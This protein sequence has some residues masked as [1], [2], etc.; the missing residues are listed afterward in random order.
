ETRELLIVEGDHRDV[1]SDLQPTFGH[2]LVHAERDV[3]VAGDDGGAVGMSVEH[4]VQLLV[5]D[6]GAPAIDVD[7]DQI[8]A[9]ASE[10]AVQPCEALGDR[11]R[12]SQVS[13]DLGEVA[14][15]PDPMVAAL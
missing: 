5:P 14:D 4:P 1:L 2:R 7:A 15:D 6:L 13:C 12:T 10:Y 3:V 11:G 8:G 9:R